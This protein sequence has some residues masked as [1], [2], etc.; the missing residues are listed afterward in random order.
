MRLVR[1]AVAGA[2][3]A[4]SVTLSAPAEAQPC[5]PNNAV[6]FVCVA[7][8]S[9]YRGV[10]GGFY[11]SGPAG[12]LGIFLVGEGCYYPGGQPRYFV[13]AHTSYT[14]SVEYTLPVGGVPCV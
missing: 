9:W 8:D 13:H 11:T 5:I 12:A 1:L 6:A 14:G 3:V 2:A 7:P 10:I 4:G